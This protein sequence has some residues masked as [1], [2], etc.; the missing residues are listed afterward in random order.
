M[1][2]SLRYIVVGIG[3]HGSNWCK[4]PLP[5]LGRLG[6]AVPAA[7]A[8]P[9]PD[10]LERAQEY[11][12]LPAEKCYTDIH[13]AFSENAADFAVVLV[14][15][16]HHEAVVDIALAHDMDVLSTKPMADTMEGC[17][18]IYKKVKAAGKKMA[19]T[20]SHRFDQDKQNLERR[21]KSGEYGELHYVICRFTCN[22]RKFGSW[23]KF[24]HEMQDPLLVEGGVHQLDI[25][26]ALSSSNAKTT[27][28]LSWNPP[29]GEFAGDT[30]ALVTMEMEN[31]I[32]CLYEGANANASTMN[33]WG[34]DYLRAECDRGTLELDR[35]KL[36]VL[37]NSPGDVAPQSEEIPLLPQDAWSIAWLAELFCD[38]LNGGEAP[39]NDL[40]DNIQ[41]AALL[42]ATVESAHSGRVV[43]VQDF[44][45]SRMEK[46][47]P[48]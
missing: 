6:K 43:N 7:A 3:A 15:P 29:W 33:G 47:T 41:C 10:A 5:R 12:E 11:L 9:S 8:D 38:W 16:D 40:D 14:P 22:A 42:F 1:A 13:A 21:I 20:M 28:A 24:R 2:E 27:Y 31:G 26:R 25:L 19:V 17:C 4:G 35:R 23:G 32:K 30:T 48:L 34:Q 39:P 37:H 46:E 44:L 45:K 36:R 18:R